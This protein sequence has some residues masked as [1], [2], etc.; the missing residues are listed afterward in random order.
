MNN[1]ILNLTEWFRANKRSLNV[2]KT[3]YMVF[4]YHKQQDTNIDLQLSN[5]NI[6]RTK[7]AKF[8]G[9][10]ID[11]KLKWDGHINMMKN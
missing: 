7:C 11:D 1:E 10:C 9:S 3:I 4:T 2:S 5:S 8:L 6:Q